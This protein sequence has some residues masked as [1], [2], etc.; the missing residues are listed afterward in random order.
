[1]LWKLNFITNWV[2]NSIVEFERKIENKYDLRKRSLND[3]E[4]RLALQLSTTEMAHIRRER[5][6]THLQN[7]F[8]TKPGQLKLTKIDQ[9]TRPKIADS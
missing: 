2:S 7:N 1:M 5:E 8:K 6:R 3:Q 9:S 4:R